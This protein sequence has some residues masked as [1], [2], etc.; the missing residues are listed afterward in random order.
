MPPKVPT[1]TV[2]SM[3]RIM[4]HQRESEQL[5]SGAGTRDSATLAKAAIKKPAKIKKV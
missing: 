2:H 1:S 4:K 5:R 3:A